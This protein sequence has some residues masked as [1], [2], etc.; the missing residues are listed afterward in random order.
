MA[1]IGPRTT[2]KTIGQS[3][4]NYGTAGANPPLPAPLRRLALA[5][6][7]LA[8]VRVEVAFAQAGRPGRDLDQ[9]IVVDIGDG[10]LQRHPPG[11][12][13]A[14]GV[15]LAGR[16]EVGELLA[17]HRVDLKVVRLGVLADDHAF[18]E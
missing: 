7:A 14:D 5:V 8:L 12:G 2:W 17:L 11:R 9:V 6:R 10:L 1:D 15:V 13:E 4:G 18:V 3:H 16:A